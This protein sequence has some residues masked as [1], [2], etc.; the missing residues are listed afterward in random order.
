[1][2][3]R[4]LGHADPP[5]G[6][7]ERGRGRAFPVAIH[8][9]FALCRYYRQDTHLEGASFEHAAEELATANGFREPR[10][11]RIPCVDHDFHVNKIPIVAVAEGR[12]AQDM[13]TLA[14]RRRIG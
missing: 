8:R 4:A 9:R 5:L 11:Q 12:G 1:M 13:V 10:M 2:L 14:L 7:G 3:I 6:R